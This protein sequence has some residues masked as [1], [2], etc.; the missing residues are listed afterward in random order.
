MDKA[1]KRIIERKRR[2]AR[3]RK[4]IV[5]STER[6]RMCV[7]RSLLHIYA[8]IIDDSTGKSLVQIGSTSKEVTAR[9]SDEKNATKT[10]IAK[11]V[12]EV[13]A[14]K[15]K[16][17]GIETVVFDRKGYPFHGRVK[18]MADAAREKGLTF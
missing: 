1:S 7:R 11:I 13:I 3:V 6:P 4:R 15:A 2:A 10:F 16:E 18:V 17:Q 8:Q 9:V 14:E 12:G 5:G